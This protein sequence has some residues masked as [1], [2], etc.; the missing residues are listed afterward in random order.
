MGSAA[1][2]QIAR[3]GRRV[4]ALE[5]FAI[6]HE[7]GSSHGETRIIRK[8]YFEDPAY[9]PL[10][11]R[12]YALWREAERASGQALYRRTGLLLI[13]PPDGAVVAGVRRAARDHRLAIEP[14]DEADFAKRFGAFRRP[15]DSAALFEP[16][17]G[18]LHVEACVAALAELARGAGAEIRENEPVIEWT[19]R[20]DGVDV[21]T[22]RGRYAADQLVICG[23]AWAGRLLAELRLPLVV[24]RKVQL[25]FQC[26]DARHDV[27][28][29]APVWCYDAPG[30]FHYGF[31]MIR[32]GECKAALHTGGAAVDDP[33]NVDRGLH[34]SDWRAVG[35]FVSGHLAGVSAVPLRHSVCMYTMT[36]DEHFLVDRHPRSARVCFAAGFSGHGFKF[37]PAI[38]EMLAE[39]VC[40]G[41][42]LAGSEWLSLSGL[43]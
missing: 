42:A 16:E 39:F 3:R 26:Q 31:P 5:Q 36:P 9:V 17:A 11:E 37:C 15:V 7:R 12:S 30:G 23:G 40:E 4:L 21:R 34:E 38:G 18:Y 32:P 25:W 6:A 22:S 13:G 43:K 24:R 29:G 27:E 33:S 10:V 2:W 14:I 28:R 8:A 20:D 19:A 1:A 35:E 41:R